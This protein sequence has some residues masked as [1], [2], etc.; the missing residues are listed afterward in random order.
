MKDFLKK[1][2][3]ELTA[4]KLTEKYLENSRENCSAGCGHVNVSLGRESKINWKEE[5]CRHV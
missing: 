3:E 5:N 2:D 1:Y 4:K